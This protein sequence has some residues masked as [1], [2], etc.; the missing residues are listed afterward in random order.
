MVLQQRAQLELG[1]PL[2]TLRQATHVH[3]ALQ[4]RIVT[5]VLQR[6]L[7]SASHVTLGLIAIS[8]E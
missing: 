3:R 5:Q 6:M 1:I 7:H 8:K 2:Q 4:E